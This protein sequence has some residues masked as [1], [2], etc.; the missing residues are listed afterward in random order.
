MMSPMSSEVQQLEKVA[1]MAM[2]IAVL[3]ILILPI[4]GARIGGNR[5]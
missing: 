2:M 4:S 1:V 3:P 5:D